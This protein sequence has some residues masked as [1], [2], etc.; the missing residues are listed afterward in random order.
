MFWFD[1]NESKYVGNRSDHVILW[2]FK[3][4]L[5]FKL[6]ERRVMVTAF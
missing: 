1:E 5:I 2:A 3:V 4:D 6:T